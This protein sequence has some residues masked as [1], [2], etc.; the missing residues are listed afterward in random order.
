[1]NKVQKVIDHIRSGN[2]RYV[3][4]RIG[5][6]IFPVPNPIFFWDSFVV[7]KGMFKEMPVKDRKG[8]E[9]LTE[10]IYPIGMQETIIIELMKQFPQ[11]TY[12]LSRKDTAACFVVRGDNDK[13]IGYSW[14]KIERRQPF[15]VSNSGYK[16][17]TDS[18]PSAWGFGFFV[19]PEYRFSSAFT[20]ISQM[21]R[22]HCIIQGCERIYGE[23]NVENQASI[24]SFGRLGKK[25]Y[26][27]IGYISIFRFNIYRVS[28]TDTG[29]KSYQFRW[30]NDTHA[31]TAIKDH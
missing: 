3:A 19:R 31:V 28:D 24:K 6:K 11:H 13:I 4:N 29:K 25:I 7:T 17:P 12:N 9:T 18:N 30:T 16:V 10:E 1:M 20:R 8:S 21:M 26:A 5:R 2:L 14:M 22:R 27:S 23:T 15:F